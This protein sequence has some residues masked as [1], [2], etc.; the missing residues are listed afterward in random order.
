MPLPTLRARCG[1]QLVAAG[2]GNAAAGLGT[3]CGLTVDWDWV[4]LPAFNQ[5]NA[6]RVD[7]MSQMREA[8]GGGGAGRRSRRRQEAAARSACYNMLHS[9]DYID[10]IANVAAWTMLLSQLQVIQLL[11]LLLPACSFCPCLLPLLLPAA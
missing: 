1:H 3:D 10:Y 4:G 2:M 11:R 6:I 5:S 7:N 8:E 9:Y